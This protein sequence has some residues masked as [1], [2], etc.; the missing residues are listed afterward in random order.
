M[1]AYCLDSLT[2]Y[3]HFLMAG[4][5]SQHSPSMSS[6]TL[7]AISRL[8]LEFKENLAGS[9]VDELLS[10]LILVLQSKERQV[11]QA[12]LSFCRVLLIIVNDTVLSKYID[13]LVGYSLSAVHLLLTIF[14]GTCINHDARREQFHISLQTQTH[15]SETSEDLRVSLLRSCC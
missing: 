9:I 15:S 12:A 10:T 14:L 5:V 1:H 8:C 3:F 6:A 7:L 13:Q 11:V 4:L 2:N